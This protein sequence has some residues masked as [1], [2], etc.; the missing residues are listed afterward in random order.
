M[1]AAYG[2]AHSAFLAWPAEDRD[3]AI[4]HHVRRRSA[5]SSCGT[6]PEE[7]D[8][9]R[10]GHPQAY[11]AT[12]RRCPGCAQTADLHSKPAVADVPGT[13]VFLVRNQ[14]V[15]RAQS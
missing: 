14:E 5:C 7:W 2:I 15:S 11:K 3:K 10:G 1:C 4:W 6:R 9:A 12:A 8:P 13:K